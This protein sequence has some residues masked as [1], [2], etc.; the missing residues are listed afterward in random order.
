MIEDLRRVP[1]WRSRLA[2]EMER[3]ARAPFVWGRHDCLTG[4]VHGVFLALTD[5][6]VTFQWRGR[7]RSAVGAMRVLRHDGFADLGDLAAT[8]A[9]EIPLAR[10]LPGDIAAVPSGDRFGV[11]LGIAAGGTVIVLGPQGTA[12]LPVA[13]A[14]RFFAVGAR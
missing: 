7:Y 5:T 4:L 12:A 6:D 10:T 8:L 1:A 2:A 11:A 9:P 14:V 3:Q 13:D